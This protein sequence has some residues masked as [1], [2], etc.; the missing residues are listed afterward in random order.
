MGV[1]LL[2]GNEPRLLSLTATPPPRVLSLGKGGGR[3]TKALTRGAELITA[4]FAEAPQSLRTNDL[5]TN[6]KHSL[7]S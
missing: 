3:G 6:Q 7:L 1:L 2:S 5:L 4:P